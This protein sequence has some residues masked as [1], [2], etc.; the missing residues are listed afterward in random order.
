MCGIISVSYF[1]HAKR[2]HVPETRA[3]L[4]EGNCGDTCLLG[5]HDGGGINTIRRE[6]VIVYPPPRIF[7]LIHLDWKMAF[8]RR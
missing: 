1:G 6:K 8:A 2:L 3:G 7:V 4:A 5:R